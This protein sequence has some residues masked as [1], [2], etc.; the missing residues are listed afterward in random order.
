MTLLFQPGL[1]IVCHACSMKDDDLAAPTHSP[2]PA[3]DTL[4]YSVL[5]FSNFKLCSSLACLI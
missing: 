3:E 4:P 2:A 1:L 5:L